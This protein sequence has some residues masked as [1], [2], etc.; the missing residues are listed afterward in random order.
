LRSRWPKP[1]SASGPLAAERRDAAG[2]PQSRRHSGEAPPSRQPARPSGVSSYRSVELLAIPPVPPVGVLGSRWDAVFAGGCSAQV[3]WGSRKTELGDGWPGEGAAGGPRASWATWWVAQE[4]GVGRRAKP[5]GAGR[6]RG[7]GKAAAATSLLLPACPGDRRPSPI[8]RMGPMGRRGS[9]EGMGV[10]PMC[11]IG[12]MG[13]MGLIGAV[14]RVRAGG[15]E[16]ATGSF[17]AGE[18]RWGLSVRRSHEGTG[19]ARPRKHVGKG[20]GHGDRARQF[21]IRSHSSASGR[22]TRSDR[23]MF[24]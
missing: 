23:S 4:C 13:P 16:R 24:L 18:S 2:A 6:R 3:A 21:S 15:G 17:P 11:P 19:L 1:T 7:T 14:S 20:Q 12:P 8:G 10:P 5:R 22:R 9:Q